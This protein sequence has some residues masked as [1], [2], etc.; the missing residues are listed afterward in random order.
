MAPISRIW[1]WSTARRLR[2]GRAFDPGV[3]VICVGNLTVGGSGKTPV[4][5]EITKRLRLSGAEAHLLLAG[6]GGRLKGPLCIDP[7]RHTAADVGD[8]ALMLARDAPVWVARDRAAGARAAAQAGAEVIIMDD[9][10]QNPDVAK[11]LSLVVVDAETRDG[12]WPFGQ[13][14]VFPAGPMREPLA[15]GLARADVVVLLLP[16]DLPAPDGALVRTPCPDRDFGGP[17]GSR[18]SSFGPPARLRRPRQ[19]VEDGASSPRRRLRPR[20]VRGL[21]RSRPARRFNFVPTGGPRP[22]AKR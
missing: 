16:A 9:G 15:R 12:E 2:V 18:R 6:Y 8:E 17:S 21:S 10:H 22:G 4:A 19:A 14:G 11:S 7:A 20:R 3:P 13:G 5:R 1:S